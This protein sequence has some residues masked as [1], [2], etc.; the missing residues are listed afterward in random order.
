M[1]KWVCACFQEYSKPVL[2]SCGDSSR[3][4]L[5]KQ[6]LSVCVDVGLRSL[7]PFM[8]F[9][10]E[11]LY[12]RLPHRTLQETHSIC[13]A[14]YPK[15]QEVM[16]PS[17]WSERGV[18]CRQTRRLHTEDI[19]TIRILAHSIH[20]CIRNPPIRHV[21]NLLPQNVPVIIFCC[22][23]DPCHNLLLLVRPLS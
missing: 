17:G 13:R 4:D 22:Q 2:Q 18:A 7:S 3:V 12:Q 11:E 10:T 21:R 6:I 14:P 20:V 19:V 23:S 5:V 8:P 1:L 15:P 9:L 16:H